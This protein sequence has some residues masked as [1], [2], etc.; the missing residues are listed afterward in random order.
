MKHN[1]S[2]LGELERE[3]LHLVWDHGPSTADWV[4]K[5]LSRP[6]KESTVRTVLKR[7]EGKGHLTHSVDNRTF[8][9][10]AADT[11]GRAA[12]RAVKRIV[13]RFCSG[14]VEEVLVGLVDARIVDS[15][16]LQ[17]LAEKIAACAKEEKMMLE[18][19]VNATV[20]MLLVGAAVWLTL[21]I[22]RVRN[23]HVEILVWRMVLLAGLALP[24]LLSLRLAPSFATLVR[25]SHNSG[26]R[27]QAARTHPVPQI[28]SSCCPWMC[29][30]LSTWASRCC[31]SG[32]W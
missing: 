9:Y 14:S 16:E 10:K 3:V 4:Q 2:D 12:A 29:P 24:A 17:R 31:C 22:V 32:A 27:P 20:R 28:L 23:P 6:L 30:S 18:I 7:L 5:A 1:V 21:R 25:T 8:V 13:D 11:R 19:L 15:A 26:S